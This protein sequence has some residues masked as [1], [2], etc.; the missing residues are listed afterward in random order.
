MQDKLCV[1]INPIAPSDNAY[2]FFSVKNILYNPKNTSGIKTKETNS[3]NAFLV[4]K[5]VK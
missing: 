4:Y 5:S 2:P 3:P 1:S